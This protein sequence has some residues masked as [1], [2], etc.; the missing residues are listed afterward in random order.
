MAHHQFQDESGRNW[1]AWEVH[2]S[3]TATI[4]PNLRDGWIVFESGDDKRRLAPIPVN[5]TA[6][7]KSMLRHWCH[8]AEMVPRR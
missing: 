5:W 2:L 7:T 4:H 6:A 8:E 1:T 3:G